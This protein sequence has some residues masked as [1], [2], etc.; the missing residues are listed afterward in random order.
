MTS[1]SVTVTGPPRAICSLNSGT[2]LP[3]EPRTLPKRTTT[4]R[5]PPFCSP[6]TTISAT[7]LVAPITLVGRTALSVETC[8]NSRVPCAIAASAT[9]RVPS[10]LLRAASSTL[11]SAIG[12]CLYAA[13]RSEERRVGK[14]VDLGGR[15]IIKKKKKAV[16]DLTPEERESG[17]DR[18]AIRR[19]KSSS[20]VTFTSEI[21]G[22]PC[23]FSS[24]RRHTRWPRDWSSDVCS[25]D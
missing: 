13:A 18:G 9:L 10:T 7:R 21:G 6:C 16:E 19:S 4:N 24:R 3:L 5:Q 22:A 12:R 17:Y 11:R 20:S 8:T 14:G 23:F 15:R 25:S 1:G 2:T